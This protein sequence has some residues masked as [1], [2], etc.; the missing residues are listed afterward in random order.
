MNENNLENSE[1]TAKT[2]ENLNLPNHTYKW[3]RV[4]YGIIKINKNTRTLQILMAKIYFALL[5]LSPRLIFVFE[6]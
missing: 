1:I 5:K 4:G 6:V 3:Q 2:L